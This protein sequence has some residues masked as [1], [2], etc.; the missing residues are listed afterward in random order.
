MEERESV[1]IFFSAGET[2]GDIFAAGLVRELGVIYPDAVMEG[3]GSFA[4]EKAGMKVL[5]DITR[6]SSI[7]IIEVL[8]H[9]PS[10][11]LSIRRIKK[12]LREGNPNL[13][14]L[15]DCQ[16]VN[17][18]L[19]R[20]AKKLGI[21]VIYFIPPQNF[22]WKDEKKGRAILQQIDHMINIYKAGFDFFS[23]LGG[24]CFFSGHPVLDMLPEKISFAQVRKQYKLPVKK[25]FLGLVPGTRGHELKRLMP[26]LIEVAHQLYDEDDNLFFL[27]PAA[28]KRHHKKLSVL[29]SDSTI[30]YR[31]IEG[32]MSNFAS[33]CD[34][35]LTKSGTA[36]LD[37]A[38]VGT[39]YCVFY[40]MSGLSYF[41][42]SKIWGV[43]KKIKYVSL[44]NIL[45]DKEIARE[46]LQQEASVT[47]LVIEARK[48]L[49]DKSYCTAFDKK[50]KGLRKLLGKPGVFKRA[51][52]DIKGFLEK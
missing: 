29:L 25:R 24:D 50:L 9:I 16:G 52:R 41:I 39:P 21:P 45:A 47:N 42:F 20:A 27:L 36:A 13:L 35:I 11:L 22:I 18:V 6:T 40:K 14:V 2:S 28:N 34:F 32:E 33:A 26:I 37:I 8:R 30:P 5:I 23:S 43:A 15:V 31:I 49:Y 48:G 51:A 10:A 46:F 12:L 38:V 44:P 7:G 1:K 3:V 19:A 17:L 4:M